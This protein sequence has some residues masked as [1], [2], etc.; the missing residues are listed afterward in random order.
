MKFQVAYVCLLTVLCGCGG[1]ESSSNTV[2]SFGNPTALPDPS[3]ISQIDNSATV[4]AVAQGLNPE[5][6]LIS[7]NF[8]CYDE[9]VQGVDQAVSTFSVSGNSF[10][11]S[12]ATENFSGPILDS[13]RVGQIDLM[14][15]DGAFSLSLEF[16]E[17]GQ[18]LS[19]NGVSCYQEGAA[20]EA[21]LHRYSLNTPGS[22][23]FACQFADSINLSSITLLDGNRYQANGQVGTYQ[24]S[25]VFADDSSD[26]GFISGPLIDAEADYFEDPDS[27]LQVMSFSGAGECKKQ[28]EPKPYKRYG[29]QN[30]PPAVTPQRPISGLYI[31]DTSSLTSETR[32][33]GAT[34]IEFRSSGYMR[35]G[36]PLPGGT[37]CALTQPNGLPVCTQYQFDGRVLTL[38]TPW[39]TTLDEPVIVALAGDGSIQSFDGLTTELVT[40]V[41]PASIV[42]SWVSQNVESTGAVSCITG[43]CSGSITDRSFHFRADG[44]YLFQS[45]SESFTSTNIG[46]LQTFAQGFDSGSGSGSYRIIA[47]QIELTDND[48]NT[49]ELPVHLMQSG[50]LVI[51]EIQYFAQ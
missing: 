11:F 44:R 8:Y 46:D 40:P 25:G 9:A 47:T 39:A 24:S 14:G 23:E 4:T 27:G 42:G 48:G 35:P 49:V 21:A 10:T 2:A 3:L 36:L 32:D 31:I 41:N 33:D 15:S 20:H 17:H 51:G 43:F 6:T 16:N 30:A 38:E 18:V 50:R 22:G 37:N 45:S 13:T 28:A 7:T 12:S 26:I 1:S 5:T 29:T 34:W 19:G